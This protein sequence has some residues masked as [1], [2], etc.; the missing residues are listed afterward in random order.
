MIA[1]HDAFV[2]LRA[3]NPVPDEAVLAAVVADVDAVLATVAAGPGQTRPRERRVAAVI[4]LSAVAVG[5]LVGAGVVLTRPSTKP[6]SVA[7]YSDA[8]LQARS[9]VDTGRQG[10]PVERCRQMWRDGAFGDVPAP[11]LVDCVL[12]SGVV[13]VFPGPGQATCDV[14]GLARHQWGDERT[15][16]DGGGD[17]DGLGTAADATALHAALT[18]AVTSTRCLG[19]DEARHIVQAELA[20]LGL[21]GWRIEQAADQAGDDPLRRCAS[22]TVDAE[23]HAVRLIP[24]PQAPPPTSQPRD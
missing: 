8:S 4:G 19:R 11:P 2:A 7:C 24:V 17:G 13:A 23:R 18:G 21:D 22:V 3:A 6:V 1:G 20:R 5:G 16:D 12:P 9:V 10:D 14:L 15:G